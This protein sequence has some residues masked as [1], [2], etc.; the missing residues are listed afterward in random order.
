MILGFEEQTHDLTDYE[1]E[2]VLPAIARL[3]YTKN[4]VAN[5]IKNGE[6]ISRIGMQIKPERVR[7]ILH[8]IRVTGHVSGIVASSK[9]YFRAETE[10]EWERYLTGLSERI[11]HIEELENSLVSQYRVWK[12]TS[13]FT[14]L[15]NE[16]AK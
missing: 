7:K 11:E 5:A 3:L 8:I 9:G 16:L 10:D 14:E 4:G 6:I 12:I 15:F 1:K 2:T 13:S